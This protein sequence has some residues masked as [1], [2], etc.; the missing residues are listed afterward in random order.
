MTTCQKARATTAI[1]TT[2]VI[3]K[4]LLFAVQQCVWV[5]SQQRKW[6]LNIITTISLHEWVCAGLLSSIAEWLNDYLACEW[7][8]SAK[9]NFAMQDYKNA[10]LPAQEAYITVYEY[11]CALCGICQ[12]HMPQQLLSLMRRAVCA[13][14]DVRE[15]IS[16]TVNKSWQISLARANKWCWRKCW[17][18]WEK[19]NWRLYN[20]VA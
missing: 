6:H 8:H 13:T 3:N 5:I 12:W 2:A 16:A 14:Q 10:W 20:C 1:T 11:V 17:Q 4:R 9:I 19:N 15:Y 7:C 18:K